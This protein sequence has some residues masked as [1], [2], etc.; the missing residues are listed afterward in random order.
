M[1]LPGNN[2]LNGLILIGGRSSRM[3]KDKSTLQYHNQNQREHLVQLLSPLCSQIFLSCNA[4]QAAELGDKYCI[5]QDSREGIGPIGGIHAAFAQFPDAAW[6]VVA[7]DLPLLSVG[8][9][10]H[11]ISHRQTG[12]Q[13][14]AFRSGEKG[15]PE[16][17]LAIYEPAAYP[18]IAFGI[19][20]G[21]YSPSKILLKMDVA[22][23]EVLDE[24][25]L[26]NVNDPEGYRRT[27]GEIR[28]PLK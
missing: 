5:V 6:L 15:F 23:L 27:L 10:S 19:Q 14:T 12:K 9:L 2:P 24:N 26:K 25:E 13:A 17:L 7:C 18:E 4:S 22:W 8:T 11:L 21:Q 16:P 20:S 1:T 28:S 3:Q